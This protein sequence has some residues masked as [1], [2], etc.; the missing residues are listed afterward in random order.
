MKMEHSV[1]LLF[2]IFVLLTSRVPLTANGACLGVAECD[3]E[4]TPGGGSTIINCR[5]RQL[6]SIPSF[7]ADSLF[8]TELTLAINNI[9]AIG[10]SSFNGLNIRRLDLTGNQI[11]TISVKAFNGIEAGLKELLISFSSS[12]EFPSSSF[13]GLENLELLEIRNFGKAVFPSDAFLK[14]TSLVEMRLVNSS[15]SSLTA[16]N[17]RGQVAHLE[18]LSLNSNRFTQIPGDALV[19]LPSLKDLDL[20]FNQL[21]GLAAHAFSRFISLQSIIFDGNSMENNIDPS[22]FSDVAGTLKSLSFLSCRLGDRS[23]EAIRPLFQLTV[24]NLRL[25]NIANIPVDLFKQMNSIH[26]LILDSNKITSISRPVFQNL[27]N[28]LVSLDLHENPLS[29]VAT[30]TFTSLTRLEDLELGGVTALR[31]SEDSFKN[32]RALKNLSLERTAVGDSVWPAIIPLNALQTLDLSSA[33]I[34][35]IPDYAFQYNSRLQTIDLSSNTI[36]SITQAA[37]VGLEDS[38]TSLN[39]NN[40]QIKSLDR[41]TFFQFKYF[42]YSKL[43]LNRPSLECNCGLRWLFQRARVVNET[44]PFRFSS[45]LWTC[46]S[47]KRFIQMREE[48]FGCGGVT[49]PPCVPVNRTSQSSAAVV[50]SVSNETTHSVTLYWSVDPAAEQSLTGFTISY[51]GITDDISSTTTVSAS[52]A[53][54][55]HL[56]AGLSPSNSYQIC[57]DMKAGPEW[58]RQSRACVIATT[59]AAPSGS[60]SGSP[61]ND[62][63]ANSIIGIS[64]GSAIGGLLLIAL[65]ITA[66]IC[67]SRQKKEEEEKKEKELRR[68]SSAT[69]ASFATSNHHQH[70]QQQ[71]GSQPQV[72][73]GSKRYTR[74]K[75]PRP[76]YNNQGYDAHADSQPNQGSD[77]SR[78]QPTLSFSQ[79]ETDKILALL[80]AVRSSTSDPRYTTK[81]YAQGQKNNAYINDDVQRNSYMNDQRKNSLVE[82]HDYDVIPDSEYYNEPLDSVV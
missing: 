43:G 37:L 32:T 40:N 65:I 82:N 1:E 68:H 22:A 48:D 77:S 80:T 47:G 70:H 73:F 67:F 10:D 4:V 38:L 36:T 58:S 24:L 17:F 56:I 54:R 62:M 31:L 39:L 53:E 13:T 8:Y 44:N 15:L 50:P 72:G 64:I 28:S 16:N 75:E 11:Q 2:A 18:R 7:K 23:I 45:L 21:T 3:C 33:S 26:T 6:S 52:S 29:S 71:P 69:F 79:E 27:S 55:S 57:I 9:R 61:S 78:S 42:D 74:N 60:S 59:M 20:S 49:D 30:D 76:Y 14:L 12:A 66:V 19:T 25:N 35:K 46:S 81:P 63:S 51:R 41:C 34:S 5:N